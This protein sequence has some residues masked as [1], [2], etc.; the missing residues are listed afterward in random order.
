MT[1]LEQIAA[2]ILANRPLEVRALVQD[3]LRRATPL[4]QE[5]APT[6]SDPRICAVV[7]AI[8]ELFAARTA[9][10]APAWANGIGK[11]T[12][13]LYLVEAASRSPRVRARI[14]QESPEPLRKRNVFAP[15]GY[16]E[17]R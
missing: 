15:S 10:P 1:P 6:S 5:L 9:Q 14:E 16:L 17:M 3:Y 2:E 8:A 13:P 4:R 12:A 7:A 11:L